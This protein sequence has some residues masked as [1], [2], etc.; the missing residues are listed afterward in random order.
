MRW[1]GHIGHMG[2]MINANTI[3]AEKP[4]GMRPLGRPKHTWK[5]NN[6]MHLKEIGV[7]MWTGF[8]WLRRESSGGFI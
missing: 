8:M 2:Q 3:L 7:R 5:Y 1:A 6:K 4:E